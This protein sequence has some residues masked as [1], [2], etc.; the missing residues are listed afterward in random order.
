MVC[1]ECRRPL[2]KLEE[3]GTG[4]L[5]WDHHEQDRLQGHKA[6]PVVADDN[7]VR[8]RCDFCNTDAPAFVL[9]VHDFI[10]GK[11]PR[12]GKDQAF[13]GDWAACA[14]CA[15]L[16]ERNA[17]TGLHRRVQECWEARHGIPEP[18]LKKASRSHLWR[19]LRRNIAG[20]LRPLQ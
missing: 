10:A 15:E 12:T 8:G 13:E 7:E 9:P 5:S 19:L 20:S 2:E 4:N 14:A 3:R 17:W 1:K 6:V 11:D 18:A 16:I